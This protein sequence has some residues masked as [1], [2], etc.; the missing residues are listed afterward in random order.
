M[1]ILMELPSCRYLRNE[2]MH[3]FFSWFRKNYEH[4]CEHYNKPWIFLFYIS[5][6][7]ISF[8]KFAL[9][10]LFRKQNMREWQKM[11][12]TQLLIGYK[13]IE[14]TTWFCELQKILWF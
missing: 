8:L 14:Q 7:L 9:S 2:K 11:L 4:M 13:T 5:I 12:S 3:Y 10:E 6:Y 1:N